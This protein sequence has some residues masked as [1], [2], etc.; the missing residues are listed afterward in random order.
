MTKQYTA[1]ALKIKKSWY[2]GIIATLSVYHVSPYNLKNLS[3]VDCKWHL[4]VRVHLGHILAYVLRQY[5]EGK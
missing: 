1:D 2:K 5:N 3:N 4:K